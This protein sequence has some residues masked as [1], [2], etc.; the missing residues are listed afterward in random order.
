MSYR[1]MTPRVPGSPL[2]V[3]VLGRVSTTHQQ[4][5]NIEAS[6]QFAE[7]YLKDI[8]DGETIV[9]RLGEQGS[10][11]LVSR[12]SINEACDL[13]DEGWPDLV[14]MEDVSKPY[15]NPRWIY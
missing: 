1:K 8:Y 14:I 11:M 9:R 10:G 5:T 6:Y 7:R 4:I 3:L 15:R 12:K 2:H 13:V